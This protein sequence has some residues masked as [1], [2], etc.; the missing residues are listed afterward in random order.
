MCILRNVLES[1]VML[2]WC[3]PFSYLTF[4]LATLAFVSSVGAQ[5]I[6]PDATL[7]NESSVVNTNVDVGKGIPSDRIDGGATR[8]SNLF[9]S[10]S[11]FN[12]DAGR[13]A[14]FANPA[15][16][17]NIISRVTG[18]NVSNILGTLGVL[19]N[20]NLLFANPN[21]IVFGPNARL[22]VSGSFF[23]TTSDSFTFDNGFEFS[24]SN[25]QAP[26]LLTINIP[27]G[28]RFRDN[29]GRIENNSQFR[30][31]PSDTSSNPTGLQVPSGKTLALLGGDVVLNGGNINAPGARVEIGGL[32][33]AGTIGLENNGGNFQVNYPTNVLLSDVTL[34]DDARVSV[35][36]S[37]SRGDIFVNANIFTALRGGRLVNGTEGTVDGGDITVN[38]NEVNLSGVG[39]SGLGAGISQEVLDNASGNAGEIDLNVKTGNVS[40][41]DN[42]EI[43]GTT[44]GQGNAG[45]VNIQVE[46]GDI[47]LTSSTIFANV[48]TNARGNAGA[49]NLNAKNIFLRDGSQLQ[50]GIKGQGDGTKVSLVASE[51]VSF[52]GFNGSLPN[53]IFTDV[54]TGATGNAGD[55]DI[56]AGSLSLDGARLFA[57]SSGKGDGGKISVTVNDS[58]N[59][60]NDS[61]IF[62]SVNPDGE[63]N[64][65]DIN[66]KGG[67]LLLAN[68]SSIVANTFGKG[69][70][71]IISVTVDDSI[72]VNDSSISSSTSGQGEGDA[73]DINIRGRSLTLNDSSILSSSLRKGNAGT[74]S[75]TVDDSITLANNSFIS[76]IVTPDGEGNGGDINFNGRSLSLND[77][78]IGSSNSGKGDAGQISLTIDDSIS[79]ANNSAILSSIP[80][81]GEGTGGD[82]N[83]EGRS[84]SLTE[85]SLIFST[86]FGKGDAGQISLTIDDSINLANSSFIFT[87]LFS[88]GEGNAGDINITG[89]SLSLTENSS[90]SSGSSGKGDAGNI[91]LIIDDSINLANRSIIFTNL[92]SEGEGNAGDINIRGRSL[93]LTNSSQIDSSTSGKGNAG[94]ISVTVDDSINLANSS[95]ILSAIGAGGEGTAGDINIRGRSLFLNDGSQINSSTSGKGNSGTISVT[96]DDSINL[97]NRSQIRSA[98]NEGGE[99]IAGDISITGSSLTLTQ[100]SQIVTS[101]VRA[102]NDQSAGIGKAGNIV[103]NMT[104]FINISGIG[105]TGFSSALLA[106]AETGTTATESQAAGDI[107]VTTGDFRVANGGRVQ[108]STAN[109]GDGG[110]ITINANNFTATNG[111][112]IVTS[113]FNSGN[114]GDIKLNITDRITI[115]GAN[116]G[117]FATTGINSTGNGGNIDIDPKTVEILDGATVSAQSRGQGIA[118]NINIVSDEILLLRRGGTISTASTTD[119]G[120]I[121]IK[122]GVL[123][124]LP[125]ENTDITASAANQGGKITIDALGIFGFEFRNQQDLQSLGIDNF[126]QLT[127]S[128]ISATGGNPTLT[129]EIIVNN[130]EIDPNNGLVELPEAVVDANKQIAQN[131]CRQGGG[132]QFVATGRGGLPPN[133]TQDLNTSAVHVGLTTP[134][135]RKITPSTSTASKPKSTPTARKIV[136]AQGW[137]FNSKGQI[138]LTAYDP[139]KVGVHR[140]A[141]KGLCGA[142]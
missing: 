92:L 135:P 125:N 58:I 69:N 88:G 28:L 65:G 35:R 61:R 80:A 140:T 7:G 3:K 122:T 38:S 41:S 77:S 42:A 83:I 53:A 16:I 48:E 130:P 104:D 21:G 112:Q 76:S 5:S 66:F 91:S 95:D 84:L 17:E 121:N 102:T 14:Y 26:P 33:E 49:I 109:S 133:P 30:P 117:I 108:A 56:Q 46:N 129:G 119:G 6:T 19:G 10:F 25:P 114:A 137:I 34:G 100:G 128:D 107:T 96:V 78:S 2:S 44:F 113:T 110:K 86:S 70:A 72:N 120:D 20:A 81:E 22:D 43:S 39:V 37:D 89:R 63:G 98:I 103:I 87:N 73:G 51:E 15:G 11:N 136:P 132:S 62:S 59:I 4:P 111:G 9:H 123:V 99:G 64:A 8:G 138:V 12:V 82:I 55:I 45:S 32:A 105:E 142:K 31:V 71:G 126:N 18:S 134:V 1:F 47:T 101:V 36:G 85:N 141:H 52:T 94:T 40:L 127:T 124:T 106:S 74:I 68:D 50:S 23:A 24:A 93:F 118:G 116:S 115:A 131:A 54:E 139:S 75:L 60:A 97:A 90:I 27:I 79:L 29:P 57:T 13:G 67:S